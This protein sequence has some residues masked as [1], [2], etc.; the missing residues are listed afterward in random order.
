MEKGVPSMQMVCAGWGQSRGVRLT[1]E[2]YI[3]RNTKMGVAPES[4]NRRKTA[5]QWKGPA[6][7]DKAD[8]DRSVK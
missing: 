4:R 6:E 7:K 5:R 3:S 1:V 2:T 8:P